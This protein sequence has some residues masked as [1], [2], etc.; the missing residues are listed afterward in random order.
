MLRLTTIVL[1]IGGVLCLASAEDGARYLIVAGDDLVP[2]AQPL[3]EWKTAKGMLAKVV[4]LSEAGPNPDSVRGFIRQA[5][6]NWPVKPEY[7][8]I[9]GGP[10]HIGS[11]GDIYDCR[12]GDVTGDYHVEL[13]VGRLWVRNAREC[14]T[15]VA[16]TLAYER[17][18]LDDTAWFRSG[19]T[20]VREDND[21]GDSIYWNDVRTCH[22]YWQA[23]GCLQ[24]DS[25]SKDRGDSSRHVDTA[26]NRGTAFVVYR[27]QCGGNWWPPFNLMDP[28]TWTNGAKLP[29]VLGITCASILTEPDWSWFSDKLIRAV[30]PATLGG[31]VAYLGTMLPDGTSPPRSRGLR[32]FM[33]ALYL[34]GE[35]RLGHAVLQGQ[36]WVDSLFPGQ[37]RRYEEWALLGDPEL[38]VWTGV[39]RRL[40]VTHDSLISPGPQEFS[41]AVA[42]AGRPVCGA[43]V[44]VSMDST[45]YE[46][47][48][49][50]STGTV[51]LAIA[52]EYAGVLRV[53]VTGPNLLPYEGECMVGP[54]GLLTGRHEI[55]RSYAVEPRGAWIQYRV[56]TPGSVKL[57]LFDAA[58]REAGLLDEGYRPAGTY[59]VRFEP[60][61]LAAGAYTCVLSCRSIAVA[62]GRLVVCR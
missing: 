24:I 26:A 57:A 41:V 46:H 35:H 32:G 39:P 47:D 9:A 29:V 51:V 31:G 13:P 5:W 53:V 50:D 17:P 37:Q 12:Y 22:S 16:K 56:G 21:P 20:V 62:R 1:L 45:V 18:T 43:H 55:T 14:S 25:L 7:V 59:R 42:G 52:P 19:T 54:T 48:A 60:G 6:N 11:P 30:S 23:A 34:E 49:T 3:A 10:G 36:H 44:C 8:L 33:H 4:P 2:A 15:I 58:G 27:G 38:G 40:T 61:Q 28:F